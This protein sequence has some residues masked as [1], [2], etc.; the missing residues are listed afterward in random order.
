MNKR[1]VL[2]VVL[3]GSIIGETL[4]SAHHFDSGVPQPHTELDIT[5]PF[6]TTV[7]AV[8]TSGGDFMKLKVGKPMPLPRQRRDTGKWFAGGSIAVHNDKEYVSIDLEVPPGADFDT[9]DEAGNDL[10]S[11]ADRRYVIQRLNSGAAALLRRSRNP[12]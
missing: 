11:R 8:S 6:A 9:K 5:A 7:S 4:I 3:A 1:K 10:V 12:S 2:P